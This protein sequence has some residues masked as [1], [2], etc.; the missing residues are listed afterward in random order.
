MPR[1]STN[2]SDFAGKMAQAEEVMREDKAVLNALAGRETE[3]QMKV[4]REVMAR[5]R[6][7]LGKLARS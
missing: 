1:K 6:R 7:G 2:R 4:A 3:T 5:R